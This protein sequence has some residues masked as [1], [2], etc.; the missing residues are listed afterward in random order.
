MKKIEQIMAWY[1]RMPFWKTFLL[2]AGYILVWGYII[3][4]TLYL[5]GIQFSQHVASS[6]SLLSNSFFS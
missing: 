2:S 4:A 1:K 5:C 6:E 3:A